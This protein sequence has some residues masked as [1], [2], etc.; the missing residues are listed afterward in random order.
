MSVIII[1]GAVIMNIVVFINYLISLFI[2]QLWL[3][4]SAPYN[5]YIFFI[6]AIITYA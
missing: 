6:T 3:R 2:H 4:I 1:A 5:T